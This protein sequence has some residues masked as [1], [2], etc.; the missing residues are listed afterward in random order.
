MNEHYTEKYF[1]SRIKLHIDIFFPSCIYY[2]MK[3]YREIINKWPSLISLSKDV[4]IHPNTVA[5]WRHRD[6]IPSKYWEAIVQT[7]TGKENKVTLETLAS[8]SARRRA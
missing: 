2:S 7:E 6:S 3:T 5:V 4:G 1:Y 8:I